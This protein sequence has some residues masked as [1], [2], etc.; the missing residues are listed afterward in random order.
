MSVSLGEVVGQQAEIAVASIV[1]L[2]IR[3]IRGPFPHTILRHAFVSRLP[4]SILM[5]V[6]MITV[7]L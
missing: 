3:R 5:F 6:S 4:V 7:V 1:A 2:I